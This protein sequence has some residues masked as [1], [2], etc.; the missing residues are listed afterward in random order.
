MNKNGINCLF[1][2][3][4]VA[5]SGSQAIA[6]DSNDPASIATQSVSAVMDTTGATSSGAA[7]QSVA[8]SIE[9]A[10]ATASSAANTS[11]TTVPDKH[12]SF[13]KKLLGVVTGTIVGTPVCMFRKPIEEDKSATS[14]LTG[15]SDKGRA[16]VP[17][18][19]LWAPF[20]GVAGVL[21]APFC[22]FNNSLVNYKKPFSKEQFSLA[23]TGT[24]TKKE[25]ETPVPQTPVPHTTDAH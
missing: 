9:P 13:V 24:S 12:S 17:T 10:S 25:E 16:V 7:N 18:L 15:N 20:A 23:N 6:D 8:S 22:A 2:A 11:N 4:L 14:D 5:S 1:A 19:A 3:A 21:E